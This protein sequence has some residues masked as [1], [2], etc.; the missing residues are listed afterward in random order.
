MRAQLKLQAGVLFG[1]V[2]AASVAAM[3]QIKPG[4]DAIESRFGTVD[5]IK[6]HY[7]TAGH[8]PTVILLHGYTQTSR[9]WRPLIPKLTDRFTVIAPDL[10]GIGDSDIPQDG[11]DMKTAAIRIHALAKSLGVTK[12][13]VVGHDIG[14]NGRIRLRSAV[15]N[16]SRKARGHGRLSSRSGRMGIG[17]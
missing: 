9:M 1:F 12:A 2:L 17:L 11:L 3:S 8:G 14:S 7:L 13:R 16:G 6:I 15:P 5:G 10:P 4:S